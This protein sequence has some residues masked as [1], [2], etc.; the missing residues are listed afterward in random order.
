M[1]EFRITAPSGESFK[2]TAET[3]QQ[4]LEAI[5][6]EV[7]PDGVLGFLGDVVRSVAQGA[8]FETADE[9]GAVVNPA[10]NR[11]LGFDAPETF[12][13]ALAQERARDAAID[14]RIGIPGRIAG[15]VG[16]T[17]AAAP[18][19]APLA[20]AT[21]IAKLPRTLQFLGLGAAEGAA[22]GAGGATE[23]RRLE[24]AG[25]G[26]AVGGAVG[27]AAPA[28]VRGVANVA[29]R[30]RGAVSP[31]SNV[32]A[33]LGRA[34]ARDEDTPEALARRAVQADVQRPGVATI[35][36]VGGENV[37]GLV[38]RVAQTPGGGRAKIV[39]RLTQRQQGQASR[40][41]KDLRTLTGTRRTAVQSIRQ[42]IAE[43]RELASPIYRQVFAEHD[44]AIRS[45]EIDR[46]MSA[47]MFARAMKKA[48][49]TGKNRAIR[50]GF[51]AFNPAF[52]V[53]DDGRI[54]QQ[55]DKSTG[56]PIFP[57]LQYWDQV[58]R[59]LDQ[60]GSKTG[61]KGASQDASD[62]QGLARLLRNELDTLTTN[63]ETGRSSYK[64]ARDT[65][66]G[67]ARYLDA[68]EEGR[69]IF[70]RRVSAEELGN[71]L[72]DMSLAERSAFR[73]G[74]VSS[75]VARMGND[76]S[77]AGDMT[78]FLRSP[79]MAAK[80]SLMMPTR[81]AVQTWLN[82]LNFEVGASELTGR[83]LGN[84]ATARRLAERE[85]AQGIVGDLVL[86][87]LSGNSV[88]LLRRVA[89]AGPR[90]LRDKLRARAD[91]ELAEV[92]TGPVNA[93]DLP[94]ILQ[95]ARQATAQPSGLASAAATAAGVT[96]TVPAAIGP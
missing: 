95:G 75:I 23:G 66:S 46:L 21:G 57:N 6:S 12:E 90:W 19:A 72:K 64:L 18:V 55:V 73:E 93:Q 79:E 14:P 69:D 52:R 91:K 40:I 68:I 36:D 25:T 3:E 10:V 86:D 22:A 94:K 84:S 4:A 37:R 80:V 70:N 83:A 58:K 61:R 43:R 8:T 16:A 67:S 48:N 63:P 85:D 9:V 81:E 54:L 33:D 17:I 47:P 1:A 49:T 34:I 5:E 96:S 2:I 53:T 41:A 92:L 32:A 78:K 76:A 87:A 77:K 65:W 11:A 38:E 60:I 24:G 35:A 13:E 88:S 7:R 39:P 82:R 30:V 59:E 26:A 20:I 29:N 27:A 89:T 44:Q 71:R 28:V 45:T 31:Q 50:E 15:A 62:A 56:A 74:A 51:G 42:T